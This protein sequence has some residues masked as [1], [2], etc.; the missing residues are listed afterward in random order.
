MPLPLQRQLKIIELPSQPF[1]PQTH[2]MKRKA[3]VERLVDQIRLADASSTIYGYEFRFR[4]VIRH[5]KLF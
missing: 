3:V 5:F 1:A 4:R 2:S